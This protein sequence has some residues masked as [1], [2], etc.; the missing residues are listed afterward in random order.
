MATNLGRT[1]T[2]LSGWQGVTPGGTASINLPVGQRNHRI[3]LQVGGIYFSA[4]S[5]V[6]QPL[7]FV[8]TANSGATAG[9]NT[10]TPTIV[11]G[12]LTAITFTAGSTASTNV[13]AGDLISYVDPTGYGF[14]AVVATVTGG[15][16]GAIATVSALGVGTGASRGVACPLDPRIFFTSFRQTVNSQNMRDISPASILGIL[17]YR[18]YTPGT[19]SLPLIFT[20]PWK[21]FLKEPAKNSWDLTGQN[22]YQIQAGISP[23]VAS[24]YINGVVEYDKFRNART[25]TAS[26]QTYLGTQANGQPWPIGSKVPFLDPITQHESTFAINAGGST[27][28]TTLN[29]GNPITALYLIGSSPGNIYRVDVFADQVLVFQDLA[30]DNYE[31]NAQYN[32]QG[33]NKIYAPQSGGGGFGGS[34]G[35]VPS[36]ATLRN[37][38][39]TIPNGSLSLD[40]GSTTS[41]FAW[42]AVCDFCVDGRDWEA[43]RVS[44]SLI[45][46]VY[47]NATQTLKVVTEARP[48]AYLG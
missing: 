32:N 20:E 12:Q 25:C 23:N 30:C 2:V 35:P 4:P 22:T 37:Q 15:P 5:G 16:P 38:P 27:D 13:T 28:I 47:S 21:N 46:R 26:N 42:D 6:A 9:S 1:R 33:G 17:N 34:V 10:L 11:N 29:F 48:Q 40:T 36:W 41:P 24:P 7:V 14:V 18:G 39:A 45:L 3:N 31:A 19:G 44:S 8:K 43:L